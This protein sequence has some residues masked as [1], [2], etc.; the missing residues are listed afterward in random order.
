MHS[1]TIVDV[2]GDGDVGGNGKPV[3]DS[4]PVYAEAPDA[5]LIAWSADGDRRAFDEIMT[6]HGPFA[7]RVAARLVPDA[8]IAD[9][10]IQEA[11]VRAWARADHCDPERARFTTSLSRIVVNLCI[12]HPTKA[13]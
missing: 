1:I 3:M 12:D 5:E 4:P 13:A 11:L 6:R 9:E 10:L 7:L 2:Q 8:A